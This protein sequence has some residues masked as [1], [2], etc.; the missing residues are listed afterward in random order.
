MDWTGIFPSCKKKQWNWKLF[1]PD[2]VN[3]AN[4]LS[5]ILDKSPKSKTAKILIFNSKKIKALKWNQNTSSFC[6]YCND[7]GHW[8]WAS[9][10][11]QLVK[12]SAGNM[13][14]LGP[15]PGLGRFPGEGILRICNEP[16]EV[17]VSEFVPLWLGP[18]RDTHHFLHSPSA[19]IY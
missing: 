19:L 9:L 2:L 16:Q 13:G 1:I 17:P 12:I 14:D 4:Q 10:V 3:L 18:L 6:F 5:Y 7:P 11:A 8:K 15:I